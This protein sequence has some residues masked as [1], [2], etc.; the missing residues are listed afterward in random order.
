VI[1]ELIAFLAVF[2]MALVQIV[3][4]FFNNYKV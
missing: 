2:G 3:D 4:A 1:Y